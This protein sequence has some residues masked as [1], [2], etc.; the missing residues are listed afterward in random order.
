M[1]LKLVDGALNR[2]A[3]WRLVFA[4]WQLGTRPQSDPEAQ[5]VRD[6]REVT[7]LMRAELN[8]LINVLEEKGAF[9]PQEFA[10]QLGD[11]ADHLSDTYAE[12]FPGFSATEMGINV[13]TFVAAETIK[14]WR[15]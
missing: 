14:G 4:G 1:D 7:M 11:E 8:A 10:E 15:P 12:K 2:L 3:K 6:H 13:D 5:A 9:T